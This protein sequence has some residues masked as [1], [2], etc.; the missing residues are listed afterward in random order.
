MPL[1]TLIFSFFAIL[2]AVVVKCRR[3]EWI[4]AALFTLGGGIALYNCVFMY[5]FFIG[6]VVSASLRCV[7]QV[8]SCMIVPIA[9][10]YFSEQMGHSWFNKITVTLWVLI[11]LL[12]LP[13]GIYVFDN[14]TPQLE[15]LQLDPMLM[16]FFSNGKEVFSMHTADAVIMIQALVTLWR[17]VTMVFMLRQYRLG[18]SP[19][20]RY[21]LL[22]WAAAIGFIIFTSVHNTQEFSQPNL[23]WTY[24]VSYS[25]LIVS[26][27]VLLAQNF[28]LRPIMLAIN[29]ESEEEDETMNGDNDGEEKTSESQNERVVVEDVDKYIMRSKAMAELLKQMLD[30]GYYLDHKANIDDV[31]RKL[32]TNRTYLTRMVKAEFDCTFTELLTNFRMS[33]AQ[34][35]LRET[36]M[37]VAEVS[38]QSGFADNHYFTRRFKKVYGI[39]PSEYRK[40][41]VNE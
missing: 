40:G 9:Y 29:D 32:R 2:Y 4:D 11:I 31:A 34:K 12:L 22:W 6:E 30:S 14:V 25:L 15:G 20:L 5:G 27:F 41:I 18:F 8:I 28:N 37:S 10:M 23:L 24:Y 26:I 19:H 35:L 17:M 36:D 13:T 21:F 33:H 3:R 38:L 7:Q 39:S 1:I 16:Y